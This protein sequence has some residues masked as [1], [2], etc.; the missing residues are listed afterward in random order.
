MRNLIC[1]ERRDYFSKSGHFL[2]ASVFCCDH[3][4][5]TNKKPKVLSI[6]DPPLKSKNDLTCYHQYEGNEGEEVDQDK[7][8]GWVRHDGKVQRDGGKDRGGKKQEC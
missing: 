6:I 1:R 2:L 7:D 5:Q 8:W 3:F 4:S